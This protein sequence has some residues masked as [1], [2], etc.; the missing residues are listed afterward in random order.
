MS[1]KIKNV[2][3]KRILVSQPKPESDKSPYYDLAQKYDI[4]IDFRPF[5]QIEGISSKDFRLQRI[6]VLEHTA[7]IFTSRNAVDNFFR[8]AT[9]M[10]LVI[11]DTMKYFCV[12]E[13]TAYYLQK[14]VQYRKRKIFHGNQTF[15]DLIDVLKKH[16]ED[17]FLF[18]C[19]D[20]KKN[21]IS[22]FL[23]KNKIKCTKAVMFKTVCSNL[24]DLKSVNYDILVFFSP[25]GIKSLFKNFP[26]FKQG[27]TKIAAFGPTTT[28]AV[29]SA[30][31]KLNIKAP[32]PIAPSMTMALEQYII[33]VA[34]EK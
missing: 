31:L 27:K 21:E 20:I 28:K 6:S 12:T 15:N 23:D 11:P 9:E 29:E 16:K 32:T 7:V 33:E 3:V 2:K 14:Y 13:S 19:S 24:K 17:K 1:K 5:T 10:R 22:D 4:Q 30:G 34:K 26:K 25:T 18:P 8:I